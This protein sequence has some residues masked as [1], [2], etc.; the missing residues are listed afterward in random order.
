MKIISYNVNGIRSAINKG[1]LDWLSNVNPDIFCVQE[2][3]ATSEQIDP[4]SFE[5]IGYH[6]VWHSAQKKGYSGVATFYKSIPNHSELGMGKPV[7]DMEGRVLRTDFG[8]ITLLNCYFPSGTTGEERQ[9]FKYRF[10]SDFANY[11]IDLQ[12]SRPNLVICGDL[13][14]A[15]R[16]IDIHNPVSNKNSSG[17]LPEERAWL[18]SFLAL[19]FVDT[20]R[21]LNPAPHRYSW[22]TYRAGARKRNLGWRIDYLLAS[23]NLMPNIKEADILDS[24]VHSDHCPVL[25]VLDT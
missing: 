4:L 25:L 2:T 22:W 16:E 9:D 20:F 15:H 24:V 8:H 23:K 14:I 6:G 19:G 5:A 13:N 17:F 3:K 10:L 7:Y 12:K 21:E 11:I 1:L 18:S